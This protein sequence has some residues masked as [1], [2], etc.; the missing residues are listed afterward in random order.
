MPGND[1]EFLRRA[2]RLAMKGRGRVEPNPMVGCVIV[3]DGRV[4]GEAYHGRFGG[5]HAEPSALAACTDNCHGATA[6]VTLEPCCHTNK[7]TPPCAPRLIDAGIARVVMGCMDPNPNVDG[8]GAAMLRNA[9]VDVVGPILE[10]ETRQLNA[11][12]FKGTLFARPYVTL[13]WAESSNGRVAGAGGKRSQ[14]SNRRAMR[15]VHEMRARAD[16]ILVGI[17]TVLADDPQLTVRNVEIFRPL[18][19]AVLDST[20][21]L[22]MESNLA[23]TGANEV[24]VFCSRKTFHDSPRVAEL[25]A[26]GLKVIPMREASPGRL[27]LDDVLFDLDDKGQHVLIEAGPTLAKNFFEESLCD[28]VWVIRSPNAIEDSTAPSAPVVPATYVRTAEVNLDGD[29]LTEYLN[30]KSPV[31]FAPEPSADVVRLM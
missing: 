2:I 29:I 7:K 8:K 6:Y 20:L 9:G 11:A 19:R 16:T 17:N 24:I 27:S 28:R 12:F 30:P 14:I 1:S 3:K 23:H 15:V 10:P 21:Q 18:T 31:F 4:I 22:P 25:E 26:V 5:P 13:K